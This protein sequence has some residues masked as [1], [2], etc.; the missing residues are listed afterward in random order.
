[1][2]ISNSVCKFRPWKKIWEIFRLLLL[3]KN[4]DAS[5]GWWFRVKA[6]LSI[7]QDSSQ[8]KSINQTTANM[9]T[10]LKITRL[11]RK[12]LMVNPWDIYQPTLRLNAKN[13]AFCKQSQITVNKV[14]S[15]KIVWILALK[16]KIILVWWIQEMFF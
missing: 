1:M 6:R 7:W 12:R 10:K 2:K 8:L 3:G 15:G 16:I 5:E 14:N 4:D 13:S 9:F 11:Q